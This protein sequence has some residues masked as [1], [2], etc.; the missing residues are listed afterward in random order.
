MKNNSR[1]SRRTL[2][3]GAAVT[4]GALAYNG[5][6]G[7]QLMNRAF[8]QA[9]GEKSALLLI[10]LQGGYNAVFPSADS[11]RTTGTFGITG[12]NMLKDLGNGLVVDAPTFGTL[13][14]FALT[15]M[16]SVGVKHGISDH[17]NAQ[18]R[19]V[20]DGT[21]AYYLQLAAAMGGSAAIKAAV[22]G[23]QMPAGPRPAESGVSLQ[24]IT[25]MK[26]TIAAL[27]GA[28][29]P[30]IPDRVIAAKGMT[31]A[32]EQSLTRLTGSPVSLKS[33]REGYAASIETLQKPV[34]AFDFNAMALAYNPAA[35]AAPPTA[36]NNFQ[37][38]MV[39]AELMIRAGANVVLAYNGGWDTH[40]DRT[41]ANVRGKMNATGAAGILPNLKTFITRTSSLPEFADK[42]VVVAIIGD[43]S[44]SL[45]GSDHQNS[46]TATVIGK[47]VKVGTSGKLRVTGTN[48][49]DARM[50]LDPLPAIP[51]FWSYLAAALKVPTNPFGAN[52]H[53]SL[54]L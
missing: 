43:F 23:A 45:P 42:N 48:T 40:G 14:N 5:V 29:D 38:Q 44:R 4:A 9:A 35:G 46:L 27:G 2:L 13:P 31:S 20:T 18:M 52:V 21:R 3:Q 49:T 19:N 15:H 30:T 32:Q 39:A 50:V 11:F 47:Y 25:D 28:T 6:P 1:F 8:G 12:D 36:V 51:Q 26:T 37:Q 34:Q 53:T 33:M 54:L 7:T 17:G 16:A 10:Y 24:S 22:V 41:A